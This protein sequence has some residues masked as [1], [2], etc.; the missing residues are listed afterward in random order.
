MKLILVEKVDAACQVA[1]ALFFLGI[2][3]GDFK[4]RWQDI[5]K[6]SAKKLYLEGGNF[7]LVWT[8]GHLGVDLKPYEINENY[9]FNFTFKE[10][11]DYTLP[12]LL[13][14]MKRVVKKDKVFLFNKIK[15][16]VDKK[17]IEEYLICTDADAEGERIARDCL[18]DFCKIPKDSNVKRMWVTGSFNN[19]KVIKNEI[20]NSK[21]YDIEKY[22]NLYFSQKV[23]SSG[24]FIQG[25]KSTKLLV[26]MYGKKLYSGRV[27]N[28]II[29]LIG[30]RQLA[31]KNYKTN[32]YYVINSIGKFP[33]NHFYFKNI[34]DIDSKG[35]LISKIDRT[36]HYFKEE[37]KDKVVKEL[38]DYNLTGVITKYENKKSSSTT[39]PLPLSGDDFK[40]EMASEYKLTLEDSGNILQYL[41]DSGFTT[42]QGTN[43]RYFSLSDSKLVETA[44]N[45][46]L[47]YFQSDPTV[48][49]AKYT[50]EAYLFSDKEAKKQNHPPLHLT[51]KIPTD[52][53]IKSWENS[54][55]KY[56]KEGYELIAK[57]ILLHF[58][59][60]DTFES[61]KLEVEINKHKFDSKGIK[62]LTHGW[63]S[64]VNKQRTNTYFEGSF[65]EG[66][67]ITLEDIEV[68]KKPTTKPKLYSESEILNT[69]MNVS[70][71]LNQQIDDE[72][73]PKKKL[74][75]K[76][77][78]NILKNVEGIGTD[79]TRES[80]L[81]ELKEAALVKVSKKQFVLTENGWLLYNSLPAQ[82]RS[83][84][85]TAKWEFDFE[86]IR[87]GNKTY[88]EVIGSID[89]FT[90]KIISHMIKN[91]D[92]S[93]VSIAFKTKKTDEL[94]PLCK[95]S[96]LEAK[97]VFKCEKN[98]YK[99]NKQSGCKFMILKA[100]KLLDANFALK[101]FS[102]ILKGETL[103]GRNG[104]LVKLDLGNDFFL[105]IS[106]PADKLV[107]TPKTFRLDKRFCFKQQFG[108]N[109]TKV[110]AEKLLKGEEVSLKRHSK[111]TG[112]NYDITIW[113]NDEGK[114][115]NSFD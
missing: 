35:N 63:R 38:K 86:E 90:Q 108:K 36:T 82:L 16:V 110:Q 50:T 34:E 26:D 20:Q 88:D 62:P 24:D 81:T 52:M 49:S 83:V 76:K 75:L 58:L 19:P 84:V 106:S 33:M 9:G 30:D 11:F 112:K 15:E 7:I 79:R 32:Y 85:F 41:R 13:T 102:R 104:N 57:R 10:N 109:L 69:L 54:K 28:T 21:K 37:D 70:K 1:E 89:I 95:S 45:T 111:K 48:K 60:N 61:V 103:T 59:E 97:A 67:S 94:C 27:K 114:V 43:G 17:D 100:Q 4:N 87:R 2:K 73:D 107:E 53:D 18:F 55:I 74:E 113:L 25:M 23:R 92:K 98:L 115:E 64:F 68:L 5:K 29:G 56:L 105:K 101:Q 42:Y 71:V 14:D 22:N 12:S 40:S 46:A 44:Y 65:K 77:A 99:D 91:R 66:D 72:S 93:N 6:E 80:I 51:D 39:R 47:S 78:R 31:I 3:K 8:N 96:I